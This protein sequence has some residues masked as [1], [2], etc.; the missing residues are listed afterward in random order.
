MGQHFAWLIGQDFEAG[1]VKGGHPVKKA[2][3]IGTHVVFA[4]CSKKLVKHHGGTRVT[5]RELAHG[6]QALRALVQHA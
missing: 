3:Q 6:T 4:A 2:F 1:L 5:A